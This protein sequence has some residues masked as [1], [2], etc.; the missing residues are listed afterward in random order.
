MDNNPIASSLK[1]LLSLLIGVKGLLIIL[2]V[3]LCFALIAVIAS[4]LGGDLS[5][6]LDEEAINTY[7]PA[8]EEDELD[9]EKYLEMFEEAGVLTEMGGFISTI[10]VDNSVD[11]VLLSAIMLHE[12]DFG[13]STNIREYN[14]PINLKESNGSIIEYDT[15]EEGIE[16]SAVHLYEEYISKDKKSIT[17][18]GEEFAPVDSNDNPS[19]SNS[20]WVNYV[21]DITHSLGGLTLNCDVYASE[22]I[23][24]VEHDNIEAFITSYFG[25]RPD[26]F[27]GEISNHGGMDFAFPLGTPL[28]AT[29]NGTVIHSNN[30]CYIQNQ[31]DS[32]GGGFG[33]HIIIDH[34][35]FVTISAHLD[36]SFVQVGDVVSMGEEIGAIG[37]TGRSTGYHL[38]FEV[39]VNGVREDPYPYFMSDE[40][41]EKA[42]EN[43]TD[44][45]SDDKESEDEKEDK[46]ESEN[47]DDSDEISNPPESPYIPIG[48]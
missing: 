28:L 44:D 18:I 26:P 36:S 4:V 31:K 7:Y 2:G 32:C 15:I 46:N 16:E 6:G 42:E 43:K 27:T 34:G 20:Q 41:R 9:E 45:T 37:G 10:A 29:G 40:E 19:N 8:C 35:D 1:M 47:N 17:K 3:V 13:E 5:S 12:S 39:R 21:T 14:N 48:I 24:P 33:N 22:L 30:N 38:H 25:N 11:P 23:Y